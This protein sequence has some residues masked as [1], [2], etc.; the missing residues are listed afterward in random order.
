MLAI[1]SI[2]K[3]QCSQLESVFLFQIL[4]VKNRQFFEHLAIYFFHNIYVKNSC[5]R[6]S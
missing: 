5:Q 1:P 3:C 2:L 4:K 6:E